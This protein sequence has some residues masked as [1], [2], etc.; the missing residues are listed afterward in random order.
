MSR[1]IAAGNYYG[2]QCLAVLEGNRGDVQAARRHFERCAAAN[3]D[4]AAMWQV[5][6]A[7]QPPIATPSPPCRRVA[8]LVVCLSFSAR[9]RSDYARVLTPVL[10]SAIT[11]TLGRAGRVVLGQAWG[12]METRAGDAEAAAEK[13]RE[14]AR[15]SPRNSYVLQ[16]ARLLP[17]KASRWLG[18]WRGRG[19][20]A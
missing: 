8:P 7:R 5:R 11:V 2:W 1:G 14:G 19:A 16:V 3:P 4:N 17:T 6:P 15:V 10:G 9:V 13:F 20:C 18:A 12:V